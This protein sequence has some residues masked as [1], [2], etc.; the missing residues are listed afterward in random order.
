MQS[1]DRLWT[2]AAELSQ[3]GP[4]A[5]RP[6]AKRI[7]LIATLAE[8]LSTQVYNDIQA[9]ED[10]HGKGQG[11]KRSED[12]VQCAQPDSKALLGHA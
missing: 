2:A 12:R 1:L 6:Y 7:R 11:I 5:C 3:A 8:T 10:S 4:L 9:Y